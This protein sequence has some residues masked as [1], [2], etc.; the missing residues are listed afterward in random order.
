MMILVR[1]TVEE[2]LKERNNLNE[3]YS[4][5]DDTGKN[6]DSTTTATISTNTT[7]TSIST[8]TSTATTTTATTTTTTTSTTT[9]EGLCE[10]DLSSKTKMIRYEK[11]REKMKK[12]KKEEEKEKRRNKK[13][14]INEDWNERE[15]MEKLKNDNDDVPYACRTGEL[16]GGG[17][18]WGG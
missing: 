1:G 2:K 6:T 14:L 13:R 8:T 18:G 12:Q 16:R 7:T 3:T 11:K 4:S 5:S 15:L 9:T 17:E 10:Y